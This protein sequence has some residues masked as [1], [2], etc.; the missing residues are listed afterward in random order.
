M[1]YAWIK[2]H[3][4]SFP[5]VRMCKTLVVSKSGYYKWLKREPGPR[6]QRSLRIRQVV[7]EF[8]EV[9]MGFTAVTRLLVC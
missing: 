2:A 1:K 6:E 8:Y 3:R 4:D 9:L 7:R 5:V